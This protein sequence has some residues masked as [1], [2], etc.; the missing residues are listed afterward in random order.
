M[1]IQDRAYIKLI[2]FKNLLFHQLNQNTL[3]VNLWIFIN[4][5]SFQASCILHAAY[6]GSFTNSWSIFSWNLRLLL[7]MN[8]S[9]WMQLIPRILSL[10]TPM[11]YD[12]IVSVAIA[13]VRNYFERFH[14]KF[15]GK[16]LCWSLFF[17]Q[18]C[19]A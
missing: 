11:S 2:Y 8:L 4:T 10:F 13:A 7:W 18:S 5:N 12:C 6:I 17:K 19:R 9:W 16:L 15:T 14:K 1:C 3:L